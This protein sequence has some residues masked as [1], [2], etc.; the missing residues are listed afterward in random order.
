MKFEFDTIEQ[1]IAFADRVRLAESQK[2]ATW[3][4]EYR[5]LLLD[6]RAIDAI[7]L[8]RQRTGMGLKE[9]KDYIESLRGSV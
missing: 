9:A 8:H 4:D 5:A 6:C 7:K 2:K 1:I 3:D